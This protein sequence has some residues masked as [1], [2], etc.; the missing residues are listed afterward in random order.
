MKITRDVIIDLLP[1]YLADEASA[2]TRALVQEFLADNPEFARIVSASKERNS[3]ALL[4][5]TPNLSPNVERDA[6]ARTRALV[7]RRTWTIALAV[8]FTCLPL[9]F[10]FSDGRV[11]FLMLRDEP[12]SRLLWIAAAYLW[13]QLAVLQRR[14]R[15]VGL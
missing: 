3:D 4:T 5:P 10:A 13:V 9:T 2:D 7:R 1:A 14:L 11:T 8:F 6:L 12:G 15:G